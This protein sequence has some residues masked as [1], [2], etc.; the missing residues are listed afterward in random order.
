MAGPKHWVP[1]KIRVPSNLAQ[2]DKMEIPRISA[3][4]CCV[5]RRNRR[6]SFRTCE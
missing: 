4:N 6:V 3:P 1:S 5:Q 2:N